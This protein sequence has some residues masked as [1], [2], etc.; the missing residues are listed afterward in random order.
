MSDDAE[1]AWVCT[2]MVLI[3]MFVGF[4]IG[5]AV[6]SCST[7]ADIKNQAVKAGA[8]EWVANDAGAAQFQ[9]KAPVEA[10]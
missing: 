5:G 3:C 2:F 4:L 7:S 8:A 6:G 9:W 1:A 10:P